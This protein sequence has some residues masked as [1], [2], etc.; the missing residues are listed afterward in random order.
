MEVVGISVPQDAACATLAGVCDVARAIRQQVLR[1]VRYATNAIAL[2]ENRVPP[3][4]PFDAALTNGLLAIVAEDFPDKLRTHGLLPPA[5]RLLDLV[6]EGGMMLKADLQVLRDGLLLTQ[7]A[8]HGR[9]DD[10]FAVITSEHVNALLSLDT[11][12]ALRFLDTA[13]GKTVDECVVL[14]YRERAEDELPFD[15]KDRLMVPEPEEC[16][17]CLRETFLPTGWDEFGG[18]IGPGA[19]IACGHER[20]YDEAYDMAMSEALRRHMADDD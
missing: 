16:D 19:C 3:E 17:L 13:R 6:D 5:S 8:R 20:T 4:A 15:P 14:A 2:A 11:H 10:E 1:R 9:A 7:P 12:P 18:E